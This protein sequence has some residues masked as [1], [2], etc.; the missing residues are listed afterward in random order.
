MDVRTIYN[1]L[2]V[3]GTAF[4]LGDIQFISLG[5][6][7]SDWDDEHFSP[8]IVALTKGGSKIR[9]CPAELKC[10]H[11]IIPYS[12]AYPVNG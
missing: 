1:S 3:A 2:C 8:S 9:F 6:Y 7:E 4:K 5:G 10:A 11:D 12:D